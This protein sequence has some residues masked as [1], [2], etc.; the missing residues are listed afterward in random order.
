MISGLGRVGALY[1]ALTLDRGAAGPFLFSRPLVIGP[2]LGYAWNSPAWGLWIGA[3]CELLW[4]G[5]I[6]VGVSALDPGLVA[7]WTLHWTL[8]VPAPGQS[9][10]VVG[11]MVAVPMALA[12]R[13]FDAGVRR[14]NENFST[15]AWRT[16]DRGREWGLWA[17]LLLSMAVLF[18]KAWFVFWLGAWGGEAAVRWLVQ[19]SPMVALEGLDFAGQWLPLLGVCVAINHFLDRLVRR[20]RSA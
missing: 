12:V 6:P 20:S 4:L 5:V 16:L 1:A 3:V 2:I 19:R 10:A 14:L 7:A 8:T 9:G 11:L 13:P 18:L 15:L 17:A